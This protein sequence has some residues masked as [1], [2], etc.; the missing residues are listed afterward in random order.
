MSRVK[1]PLYASDFTYLPKLFKVKIKIYRPLITPTL[2]FFT[3]KHCML[4]LCLVSVVL[5]YAKSSELRT[6]SC[7]WYNKMINISIW[8]KNMRWNDWFFNSSINKKNHNI[9]MG[10]I[11]DKK[12]NPLWNIQDYCHKCRSFRLPMSPRLTW[13]WYGKVK[14]HIKKRVWQNEPLTSRWPPSMRYASSSSICFKQIFNIKV[15]NLG[16]FDCSCY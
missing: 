6:C 9:T 12:N 11:I 5:Y 7:T 1:Q 2:K 13:L 8:F 15:I 14:W 10:S 4:P 16:L 3:M